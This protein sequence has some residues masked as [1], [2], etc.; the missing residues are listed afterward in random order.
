V[1]LATEPPDLDGLPDELTE[2][3]TACMERSPRKR[4]ASATLLAQLGPF[5]GGTAA[6]NGSHAYLTSAAMG[7]IEGY[8]QAPKL[9]GDLF[10]GSPSE[11]SAD[12]TF[13]S[14]TALPVLRRQ[15]ALRRWLPRRPAARPASRHDSYFPRKRRRPPVFRLTEFTIAAAALVAAGAGLGVALSTGGSGSPSSGGSNAPQGLPPPPPAGFAATGG[16]TSIELLQ[17]H[18]DADTGF[19]IHGQGW[20]PFTQV[21][22]GVPGHGTARFHPVVDGAGTFNYTFDQ[23]HVFFRGPIPLGYHYVVVTGAGGRRAEKRFRVDPPPAGPPPR[24][25]S[26]PSGQPLPAR[27]G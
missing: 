5:V 8:R 2:M 24:G 25:G 4:P 16:A 10:S 12:D 26:P 21:T 19:V 22:V 6:A 13:G 7:L 1:R 11:A 18:G 27:T 20:P 15:R 14:R 3:V 23:G 9:A 17:N